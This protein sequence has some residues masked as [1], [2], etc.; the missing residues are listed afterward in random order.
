MKMPLRQLVRERLESTSLSEAQ[1]RRLQ[2]MAGA[3]RLP[4]SSRRRRWAAAG[5]VLAVFLVSVAVLW[6][7][8]RAPDPAWRIAEEVAL[9]HLKLKPPEVRG[10]RLQELAAYFTGLD[11]VLRD[12]TVVAG[13]D[14][15]FLGGRYCSIQGVSAAQLHLKDASGKLQT[16][17]QAP[18]DPGRHPG[19]PHLEKGQPPIVQHVRG[20]RVTLWVEKGLLFALAGE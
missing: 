6:Q 16:L 5:A 11:I 3:A 1:L 17:Y 18:Y 19:L 20:V 10:E 8:D 13:A 15:R 12:S 4:G 7:A 14:G 2:A 9:N